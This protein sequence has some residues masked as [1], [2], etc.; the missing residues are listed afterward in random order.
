MISRRTFIC[1]ATTP[2]CL[3]AIPSREE[4]ME[5][6]GRRRTLGLPNGRVYSG[7]LFDF[8]PILCVFKNTTSSMLHDIERAFVEA[9]SEIPIFEF[10]RSETSP[11]LGNVFRLCVA[12]SV[13]WAQEFWFSEHAYKYTQ[14]PFRSP[15]VWKFCSKPHP[16]YGHG[17]MSQLLVQSERPTGLS[18]PWDHI[19]TKPPCW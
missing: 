9:D 12:N 5:I 6:P 4:T 1:A 19:T 17:Y 2:V 16:K 8:K 18:Y 10:P 7:Y 15:E 13:L 14:L 3:L 11:C